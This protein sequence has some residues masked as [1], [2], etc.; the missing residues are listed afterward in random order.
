MHTVAHTVA[1]QAGKEN[2][3]VQSLRFFEAIGAFAWA[4]FI[5]SGFVIG[6]QVEDAFRSLRDKRTDRHWVRTTLTRILGTLLAACLSFYG[7]GSA[8]LT[9]I[10]KQ[11]QLDATRQTAVSA[12][13]AATAALGTASSAQVQVNRARQIIKTLQTDTAA[14]DKESGTA[15]A[16]ATTDNNNSK[17]IAADVTKLSIDTRRR[18]ALTDQSARASAAA[19]AHSREIAQS[20]AESAHESQLAA[21]AAAVQA[22]VYRLP[23]A[24]V[25]AISSA[26]SVL[27]HATSA[28]ITCAPVLKE[29]CTQI[30]GAFTAAGMSPQV[31]ANLS[32]WE[33]YDANPFVTFP[34]NVSVSYM[35]GFEGP[36]REI[37]AALTGANLRV[38]LDALP[39]NTTAP[40]LEIVI[41]YAGA[42]P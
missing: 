5:V 41:Y 7:A 15:L 19:A 8:S 1:P 20:A 6:A 36:A 37:S 24:T 23:N 12:Q 22:G 29:L 2:L 35:I 38:R 21:L 4:G 25:S 27:P 30:H 11:K 3:V 16:L 28:Y 42:A 18:L 32:L 13:K 39:P 26:L 9:A 31:N 14:L 40:N 17:S 10:E 34:D 33:G